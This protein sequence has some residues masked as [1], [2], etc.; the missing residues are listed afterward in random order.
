MEAMELALSA[1]ME[2]TRQADNLT[3]ASMSPASHRKNL[4]GEGR[5][6]RQWYSTKTL[7][8][9]GYA[10]VA[11]VAVV[12]IKIIPAKT[13]APESRIYTTLSTQR[14]NVTLADG[15]KVIL[16][17]QTKLTV[18]GRT[19]YLS[20][21]AVF[22]VTQNAGEPFVVKTGNIATQVLGT[23]FGIRKY[24]DDTEV[25]VVVAEGKVSVGNSVLSIGDVARVSVRGA[26]TRERNADIASIIGWTQGMLVFRDTPVREVLTELERWYGLRFQANL[27]DAVLNRQI[28]GTLESVPSAAVVPLISD[29]LG[30]SAQLR[31]QIV[32]LKEK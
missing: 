31:G 16:A 10:A 32:I 3:Q 11:I 7:Q 28:N 18:R 4:S 21:E 26:M 2:S 13:G 27:P 19:V 30:I 29:L 23:T 14:A 8:W 12:S 22:T 1:H 24:I 5:G 25:R 20:G 9:I 17:P 6:E 15:S